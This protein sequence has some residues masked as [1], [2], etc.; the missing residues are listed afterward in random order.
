MMAEKKIAV[1]AGNEP[2]RT[3]CTR[4]ARKKPTKK[5][6]TK[7]KAAKK[8]AQQT[9]GVVTTSSIHLGRLLVGKS[10]AFIEELADQTEQR[11]R[12]LW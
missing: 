4:T 12:D 2:A 5:K 10:D 6:A 9:V 3:K 1:S 8:A 11:L 7:K